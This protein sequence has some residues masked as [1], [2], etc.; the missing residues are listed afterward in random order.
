MW[1]EEGE[2]GGK[3]QEEGGEKGGGNLNGEKT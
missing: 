3:N 1:L 2:E